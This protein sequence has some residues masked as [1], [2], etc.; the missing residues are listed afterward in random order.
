MSKEYRF[1]GKAIPRKDAAEI[2]TGKVE[3]IR[4]IK[5]P[6]MLYGKVLRSPYPHAN[7]VDIDT[8]KSEDLLGVRLCS[9]IKMFLIG[10]EDCLLMYVCSTVKFV[11][12]GTL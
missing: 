4:D 2:V 10:K 12:L 11:T 7:I 8:S 5:V 9:H 6:D 1:I 3:F